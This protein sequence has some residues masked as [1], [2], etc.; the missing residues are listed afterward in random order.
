MQAPTEGQRNERQ[1]N[2]GTEGPCTLL[3]G[4]LTLP[5]SPLYYPLLQV[6]EKMPQVKEA[7]NEY[8]LKHGSGASEGLEAL[9]GVADL[10]KRLKVCVD[11]CGCERMGVGV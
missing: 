11:G 2:R 9:P 8:F 7:M 5:P 3:N 6:M 4:G 10:L 1:K